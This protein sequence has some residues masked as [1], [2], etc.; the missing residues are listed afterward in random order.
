MGNGAAAAV[1]KK[2]LLPAATVQ[3]PSSSFPPLLP[4]CSRSPLCFP[5]LHGSLEW[6]AVP[7]SLMELQKGGEQEVDGSEGWRR[8]R[9]LCPMPLRSMF[10]ACSSPGETRRGGKR[11]REEGSLSPAAMLRHTNAR[12]QYETKIPKYLCPPT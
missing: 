3:Q 11:E 7:A 10:N 9:S 5:P 12:C 6:R 8:K 4:L 2:W 1:E